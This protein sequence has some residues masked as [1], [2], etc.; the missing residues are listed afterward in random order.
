MILV[1]FLC[2]ILFILSLSMFLTLASTL[3]I[4]IRKL[5]IYNWNKGINKEKLTKEFLINVS[6]YLFG[7]FKI[8][9]LKIDNN[10]INKW[11]IKEK[12]KNIDFNKMKT[13]ISLEKEDIKLL[14]KLKI[15][16]EKFHLNLSLGTIDMNLTTCIN[17]VFITL[18]SI[19]LGKNIKQYDENKYKYQIL[20]IYN[21]RN[22]LNL[23]F[24]CILNVK[25][26]HIINIVYILI[27]RRRVEKNERTSN[28][29]AY[30]YSHE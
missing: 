6:L 7:K 17:F 3:K 1:L 21:N 27:K 28:R 9:N 22:S 26:V 19:L 10:K 23:Q 5:N 16:L 11:N 15:D 18:V 25:K 29:R 2:I 12:V 30:A 4:D 24:S 20:P 14:K 8:F 13:D